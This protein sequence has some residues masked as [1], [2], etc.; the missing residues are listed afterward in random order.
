MEP[1]PSS[2]ASLFGTEDEDDF[3]LEASKSNYVELPRPPSVDSLALSQLPSTLPSSLSESH[4]SR[5]RLDQ[6]VPSSSRETTW[7]V[8]LAAASSSVC[9]S[10]VS[11]GFRPIAEIPVKYRSVFNAYTHF[12]YVQ[13]KVLDDVLYTD[14]GLIVS[15]PTGSG[16]TAI[17][18]LAIVRLLAN[19]KQDS[20]LN[21]KVIYMAPV[22]ALCSERYTDWDQKFTPLGLTCRELTGDSEIEDFYD[23]Q[24]VNII[25]TTPEKWDSMTRRWKDNRAL[26]HM[27]RLF[28]VDEIHLLNDSCRGPTME[29]VISRMKTVQASMPAASSGGRQDS[30][31][32]TKLRFLAVSAT[33][34]NGADVAEWLS[35]PGCEAVCHAIGEEHRPVKLRK[36]VLG[37]NQT[38]TNYK[39][40]ISLDYKLASVIQQY[41]EHKPTLVFCGTRKGT[42]QAAAVLV[43]DARLIMS[44]QQRTRLLQSAN[45]VRDAKLKEMIWK[46]VGYHHAGL[47]QADRKLVE[48]LFARGE[49]PVLVATSTLAMG[50][51]LPAHLVVIKSTYYYM[52]GMCVEYSITQILQ[53]I[54]RA[55]RPQFDD[56]ATAVI[57]TTKAAKEKYEGLVDGTQTVESSLHKHLIEHLNA[58]IVL[59]TITDVSIAL[60]WI[61][62]TFLFIRVQKNPRHYGLRQEL[63]K[64]EL[65]EKLQNLCLEALK[66]L[67][68]INLISMTDAFDLKP[69]DAGTL[70]AR[71]CIAFDTMQKFT[72][73]TGRESIR[74]LI[75][76]ISTCKEFEDVHLRVTEKGFLNALSNSKAGPN[77]RYP[78]R[79]KVKTSS[80]KVNCLMQA[81][82]GCLPITDFGLSQDVAKIFP[83][84]SRI[85]RALAEFLFQRQSG[86]RVAIEATVLAKCIKSKLWENSEHVARQLDRIGVALSSNMVKAGLT[87]FEK[88]LERKPRD[89]EMIVNRNPPF[90]RQIHDAVSSLP[91]YLLDVEQVP[92]YS[93]DT[94]ELYI[95][96]KLANLE[97]LRGLS[98]PPNTFSI[99]L[100]GDMDNKLI[101]KQKIRDSLLLRTGEW[102]RKIDIR[103]SLRQDEIELHFINESYVG[104]DAH[105]LFTPRYVGYRKESRLPAT[106]EA[107]RMKVSS[108]R[109]PNPQSHSGLQKRT[110]PL[111]VSRQPC[112]H[113]CQDKISCSHECCKSGL[114]RPRSLSLSSGNEK[115]KSKKVA[116][117]GSNGTSL[118]AEN[119]KEDH[120]ITVSQK[121]QKS[122][123]TPRLVLLFVHA[124]VNS[125]RGKNK[126]VHRRGVFRHRR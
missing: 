74:D 10:S 55:G 115:Q 88:I 67:Q 61:K 89:I 91:K 75:A 32:S 63:S 48:D 16:K 56:S 11:P 94:A 42:Q 80:M 4:F 108:D 23:L 113:R 118:R 78:F 121:S 37:Y 9:E 34:P 73:L 41:S 62:S 30:T 21:F 112:A 53:M 12:N 93:A 116:P 40:D 2:L 27:I 126:P 52:A 38:S 22:K 85:S 18:E 109:A 25:M 20:S 92:K 44:P 104:L 84:A 6:L 17:F 79:E 98:K 65:E 97:T 110:A 102:M 107:L 82:L 90:G 99:V 59:R 105:L 122:V 36:V 69:T 103:R 29:A 83:C 39:F 120:V 13:S 71:Y 51:N 106:H 7:S 24:N 77:I 50:V 19:S 125:Q 28:L 5:P 124:A 72:L 101:L 54:G 49:L 35:S 100:V 64:D 70:M 76:T 87:S 68:D 111:S 46:G 26:V 31:M 117:K 33:F 95:K 47:E 123:R 58:E 81:T 14:K 86:F 57:M 1:S 8:P 66:S 96:V 3:A 119:E 43:K 45:T 114:K 15:A 60:E